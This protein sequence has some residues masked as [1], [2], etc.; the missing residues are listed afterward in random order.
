MAGDNWARH[1]AC[2]DDD[3][4]LWNPEGTGPAALTDAADAIAICRTCPVRDACLAE[5]MRIEQG[6]ARD[7][8]HGIR[9]GLDGNQR[10][11]RDPTAPRPG[12]RPAS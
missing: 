11:Q 2:K 1:A 4:D 6:I 12:K 10:F 5:T 7:S 8:R 9:G 3:P